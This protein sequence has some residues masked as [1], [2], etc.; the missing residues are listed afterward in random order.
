MEF[1]DLVA[2]FVVFLTWLFIVCPVFGVIL[3]DDCS[4]YLDALLHGAS[5]QIFICLFVL[6][7]YVIYWACVRAF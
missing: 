1:L 7:I 2:Y 6:I 4:S 3:D 5:V